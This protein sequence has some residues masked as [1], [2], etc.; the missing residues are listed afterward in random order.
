MYIII[1]RYKHKEPFVDIDSRGF[2]ETYSTYEEA[3]EAA[4]K[5]MVIENENDFS[6]WYFDYKILKEVD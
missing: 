1:W 3:K 5:I 6:P 2:T 4:E